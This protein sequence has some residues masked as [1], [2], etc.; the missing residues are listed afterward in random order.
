MSEIHCHPVWAG[1]FSKMPPSP[2]V[3][4]PSFFSSHLHTCFY[5]LLSYFPW[6]LLR[7]F[8]SKLNSIILPGI[9]S[10]SI[11]TVSIHPTLASSFVSCTHCCHLACFSCVQ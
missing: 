6:S 7:S 9:I 10:F 11:L 5:P 4:T 3:L 8:P 2:S 1:Q